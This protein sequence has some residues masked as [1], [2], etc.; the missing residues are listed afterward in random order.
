MKTARSEMKDTL[1]WIILDIAKEK[2]TKLEDKA[3][4]ALQSET[5]TKENF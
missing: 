5:E 1:D 3:I 4:V 2:I